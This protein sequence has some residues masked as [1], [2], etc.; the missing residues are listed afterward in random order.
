[1]T[2]IY[3]T[4]VCPMKGFLAT[5]C[6]LLPLA[7]HAGQAASDTQSVERTNVE[8]LVKRDGRWAHFTFLLDAPTNC[9]GFEATCCWILGA[10]ARTMKDFIDEQLGTCEKVEPY[11]AEKF[12]K[13]YPGGDGADLLLYKIKPWGGAVGNL[14][15]YTIRHINRYKD[16]ETSFEL[17]I[18]Y[19]K[20][21][22]KVLTVDDVFVPEMAA[23]IK[24]DFG[25]DF[26]SMNVSDFGIWCALAGDGKGFDFKD[27][28]YSYWKYGKNL[29]DDF[30]QSINFSELSQHFAEKEEMVYGTPP[31]LLTNSFLFWLTTEKETANYRKEEGYYNVHVKPKFNLNDK[32]TKDFIDKNYHWPAELNKKDYKGLSLVVYTVEKDGTASNVHIVTKDSTLVVLPLEKEMERI[33]NAMPRFTPAYL[34]NIPVRAYSFFIFSFNKKKSSGIYSGI[35]SSTDSGIEYDLVSMFEQIARIY[36]FTYESRARYN[37]NSRN[38][39]ARFPNSIPVYLGR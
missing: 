36:A 2:D 21:K 10:E 19:D 7:A 8:K 5:L 11:D 33:L 16:K 29:T 34:Y 37:V 25:E 32:E 17:S 35:Y 3:R 4:Y 14:R 24:A 39:R 9:P 26:I 27:H 23:K 18:V 28:A 30:K 15:V 12:L 1:M 22:D 6:L 31:S 20:T 38:Y 13:H